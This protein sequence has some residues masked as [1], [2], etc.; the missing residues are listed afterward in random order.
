MKSDQ[1]HLT[2]L[3]NIPF[4]STSSETSSSKFSLSS[5]SSLLSE[6]N[7]SEFSLSNSDINEIVKMNKHQRIQKHLA[8]R[9]N[10]KKNIYNKKS[11]S[12]MLTIDSPFEAGDTLNWSDRTS[13]PTLLTLEPEKGKDNP[14]L[15]Q[16]NQLLRNI[17]HILHYQVQTYVK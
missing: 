7:S 3:T 9:K 2:A 13:P 17:R 12:A 16:D 1:K 11:C 8:W 4:K 10:Q 14:A 5:K 15:I 6:T